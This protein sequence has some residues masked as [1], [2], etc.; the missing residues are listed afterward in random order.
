MFMIERLFDKIDPYGYCR[1]SGLKV[2]CT[3]I[4]LFLVNA[5][6]FSPTLPVLTMCVVGAGVVLMEMPSINTYKKKVLTYIV[7]T[8]LTIITVS[9]FG[10]FHYFVALQWFAITA[11]CYVLYRLVARDLTTAKV[12]GIVL[13]I[14]FVSLEGQPA[15]DFWTWVNQTLFFLEYAAFVLITHML[16]P[17]FY[18]KI[19]CRAWRRLVACQLQLLTDADVNRT[20]INRQMI[21]D[22]MVMRQVSPL[23]APRDQVLVQSLLE[24]IQNELPN[25]PSCLGF[26]DETRQ[27]WQQTLENRLASLS[28]KEVI[29]HSVIH[30]QLEQQSLTEIPS[31]GLVS[32]DVPP[33]PQDAIMTQWRQVCQ[34][35]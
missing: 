30:K 28:G 24:N 11:W 21:D 35:A 3:A 20:T 12:T 29:Q 25:V 10:F 26:D 5:F 1:L 9:V 32:T 7:F 6:L 17:N 31:A 14:G 33:R 2:A 19:F 23:L 15:A 16:Y 22:L 8:M 34:T 4:V 13:L 18:S 27:A